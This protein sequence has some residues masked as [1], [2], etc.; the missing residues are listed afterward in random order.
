MDAH[1]AEK[2]VTFCQ[3]VVLFD[4]YFLRRRSPVFQLLILHSKLL[5]QMPS[6]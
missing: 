2:T 3:K 5:P 6:V 4:A 1:V